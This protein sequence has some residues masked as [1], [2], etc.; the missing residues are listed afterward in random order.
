MFLPGL[1]NDA[2]DE[3]A[4]ERRLEAR[5]FRR[6]GYWRWV[7]VGGWIV[8]SVWGVCALFGLPGTGI[9]LVPVG[10]FMILGSGIQLLLERM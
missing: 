2:E 1:P 6:S 3:M 4:R 10:M 5:D 9:V 7:L 8:L